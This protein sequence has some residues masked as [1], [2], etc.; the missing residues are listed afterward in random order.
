M[1]TTVEAGA[2]CDELAKIALVERLARLGATDIPGTPRLLMKHRDPEELAALQHGITNTWDRGAAPLKAKVDAVAEHVPTELGKKV[3]RGLGHT[4][5]DNPDA[6]LMSAV[7]L[8]FASA[9][10]MAGKRGLEGLIDR[11]APVANPQPLLKAAFLASGGYLLNQVGKPKVRPENPE[12]KPSLIVKQGM[13]PTDTPPGPI[14]PSVTKHL[15][16]SAR[17]AAPG[18][19]LP[20]VPNSAGSGHSIAGAKTAASWTK[21][22]VSPEWINARVQAAAANGVDPA[23]G[24]K[25]LDRTSKKFVFGT[26]EAAANKH[27]SANFAGLKA[28]LG[29]A[30]EA[31]AEAGRRNAA[32]AVSGIRNAAPAAVDALGATVPSLRSTAISDAAPVASAARSMNPYLLG[33]AALGGAALLGGG[34][35]LAHRALSRPAQ[36]P[37]PPQEKAAWAKLAFSDSGFGPT[38]G[39]FRPQYASYQGTV[40]I[41]SPVVMDPRLKHGGNAPRDQ[42]KVAFDQSGFGMATSIGPTHGNGGNHESYQGRLPLPPVV[43]LDP[44]LRKKTAAIP[45]TPKGRLASSAREGAPKTT[46]FT[47]PSVAEV[48]KPVG[49]GRNLS[50]A[51]KGSI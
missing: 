24:Y 44:F 8:P 19:S 45:L 26:N 23:R 39:V 12:P 34:A 35:Y 22:A 5:I 9:A 18:K 31:I 38:G 1:L 2:F 33:G 36:E 15:K 7:P 51:S 41:P 49:F 17:I 37:L 13:F 50:G 27:F 46:G 42:K 48:S 28:G 25:F 16:D 4:A 14:D 6:A 30:P 20:G 40:P 11:V 32:T 29:K 3:V 21:L 10:Y 43:T 47:G